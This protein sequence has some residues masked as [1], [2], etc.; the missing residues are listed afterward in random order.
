MTFF[1]ESLE[2]VLKDQLGNEKLFGFVGHLKSEL[3]IHQ[4]DEL[5]MEKQRPDRSSSTNK[6]LRV[7]AFKWQMPL[8]QPNNEFNFFAFHV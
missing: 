4:F 7:V 2:Q 6:Y 8:A 5:L 3:I 1:V